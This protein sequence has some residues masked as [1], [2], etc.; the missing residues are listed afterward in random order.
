MFNAIRVNLAKSFLRP[1][2]YIIV[3]KPARREGFAEESA[4]VGVI[5]S[6]LES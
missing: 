4:K 5:G 6:V 3:L 2:E 1:I